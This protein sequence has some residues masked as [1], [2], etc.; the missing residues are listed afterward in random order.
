MNNFE[1]QAE[2]Q[3]ELP[4]LGKGVGLKGIEQKLNAILEPLV[5]N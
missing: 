1:E 2:F 3:E 4:K 5:I